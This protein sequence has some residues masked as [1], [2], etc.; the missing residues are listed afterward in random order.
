MTTATDERQ[1]LASLADEL[2]WQ[3]RQ[4]ERVDVYNRG[5][6]QVQVVWRGG[7]VVNGA[8]HYE[9]LILMTT[10]RDLG[11]IRSWLAK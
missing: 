6:H 10:T 8:A 4:Y 3:R 7:D 1:T 5:V 2:G 11:K 9:D